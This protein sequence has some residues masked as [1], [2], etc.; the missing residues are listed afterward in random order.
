MLHKIP[1]LKFE[2]NLI[3]VWECVLLSQKFND[4]IKKFRLTVIDLNNHFRTHDLIIF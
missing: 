1:L 4:T 3:V 2:W